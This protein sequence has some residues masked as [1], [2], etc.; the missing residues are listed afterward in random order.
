MKLEERTIIVVKVGPTIV[1]MS[2][3]TA[4]ATATAQD[5]ILGESSKSN[6]SDDINPLE[7]L[8]R[9]LDVQA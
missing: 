2:T 8:V 3:M 1:W 7:L 4:I 6:P 9:R 5:I